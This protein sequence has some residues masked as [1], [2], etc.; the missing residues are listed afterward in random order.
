MLRPRS[1]DAVAFAHLTN[2]LLQG[3]HHMQVWVRVPAAPVAVSS[4]TPD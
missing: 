1:A 4:S 2:Q 3:I